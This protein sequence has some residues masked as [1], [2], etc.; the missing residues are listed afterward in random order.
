M[1]QNI[2]PLRILLKGFILFLAAEFAFLSLH[3]DPALLNVY[4]SPDMKRSRFPVSTHAPEDGALDV[5][6]LNAMFAAHVVSEPKAADEFRVLFLGDSATWGFLLQPQQTLTGQIDALG[7]T[8]GSKT[9]RAY[10]LS[11][12]N[13]SASKDLLILNKAM[14]YQPDLI[15]WPV[16][17]YTLMP[18]SRSAH[19]LLSQNVD[20]TYALNARFHFLSND[21]PL[22][23]PLDKV[24]NP[25]HAFFRSMRFQVY[26]LV[27]RATELDQIQTRYDT[28]SEEL[29]SNL[30]FEG[31]APPIVE[32]RQISIDL[33]Q[34]FY[35][36]AGKTPIILINESIEIVKNQPNSNIQYN[37]YYP[38]WVY[39][40]YRKILGDAASQNGWNYLDF[41]NKFPNQ[42]FTNTPLHLN[43]DG[44]QRLAK[45]IAPSILK[46]CP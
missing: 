42:Y 33:V 27:A 35:Q 38:R 24:M 1:K 4:A 29:T 28:V 25:Q 11:Y 30:E 17:L 31:M 13:A 2:N 20:E 22:E 41:W 8:C 16:T 23:T 10:N 9:V 3:P 14:N 44:E 40:Q 6:N 21:F 26:S 19:W 39:D 43:P 15:V 7:L 37:G 18:K 12:P 32:P 5:G 46:A 36:L 34:A 45:M